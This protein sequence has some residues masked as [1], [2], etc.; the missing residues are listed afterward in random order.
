MKL[1]PGSIEVEES[2][3]KMLTVID[4]LTTDDNGK[5]LNYEEG[6]IVGW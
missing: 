5:F 4:D 2:V 6:R 3:T 1:P